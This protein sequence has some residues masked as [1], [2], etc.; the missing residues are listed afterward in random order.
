[1]IT[2]YTLPWLTDFGLKIWLEA[3]PEER[4][5]RLAQRDGLSLEE[6]KEVIKQRDTENKDLYEKLY[7]IHL[8]SD[9]TPFHVV[10]DVN[11]L[12]AE[13]V[14]RSV[15]EKIKKVKK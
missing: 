9:F 1:M 10:L 11:K 13:E 14:A 2:S 15:L 5:R 7:G 8:G 3:S 12:S 4:A 6:A